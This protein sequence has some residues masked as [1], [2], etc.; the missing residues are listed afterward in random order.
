MKNYYDC[1]LLN[2]LDLDLYS[3]YEKK[4]I[5]NKLI[6]KK[7][8]LHDKFLSYK[9]NKY[10]LSHEFLNILLEVILLN[11]NDSFYKLFYLK[12]GKWRYG[13]KNGFGKNYIYKV[14]DSLCT[15]SNIKNMNFYDEGAIL[16]EKC[17]DI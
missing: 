9:S 11:T 8:I 7:L 1:K 12:V 10:F 2:L 5:F 14:I 17:L 13:L 3:K 16:K 15:S 4:L 6:D